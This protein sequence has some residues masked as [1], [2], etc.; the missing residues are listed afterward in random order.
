MQGEHTCTDT[1]FILAARPLT[2][3]MQPLPSKVYGCVPAKEAPANTHRYDVPH[4]AFTMHWLSS[5]LPWAAS[6][7]RFMKG[8][9]PS[10]VLC[11]NGTS[12]LSAQHGD[13]LMRTAHGWRFAHFI[14]Q[15]LSV[16]SCASLSH[17]STEGDNKNLLRKGDRQQTQR[18]IIPPCSVPWYQH[19]HPTH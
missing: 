2:T 8:K 15:C 12:V 6:W 11:G 14:A 4:P 17:L 5:A 19:F 3:R 18:Y 13:P 10:S 7:I 16:W 1:F 9:V